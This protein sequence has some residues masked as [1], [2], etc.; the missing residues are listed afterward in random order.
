MIFA[1]L[2]STFFVHLLHWIFFQILLK[3]RR[4]TER[5][6]EFKKVWSEKNN[7]PWYRLQ[8]RCIPYHVCCYYNNSEPSINRSFYKKNRSLGTR[9]MYLVINLTIV[10]TFVGG[11][12]HFSLF[13]ILLY[14]CDIVQFPHLTLELTLTTGFLFVWFPLTSLTNIA[15]ISLDQMHATIRPYTALSHRLCSLKSESTG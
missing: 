6:R 4:A 12:S 9:A 13:V 5:K 8:A 15:V 14:L 11:F 2:T 3:R 10:D 7:K 1:E